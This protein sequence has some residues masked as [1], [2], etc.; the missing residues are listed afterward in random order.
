MHIV[1]GDLNFNFLKKSVKLI[2]IINQIERNTMTVFEPQT[3]TRE[4]ITT[5]TCIDVFFTNFK[6][7]AFI[8]INKISDHYTEGP[9]S[10]KKKKNFEN[11]RILKRN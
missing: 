9:D 5:K 2:L 8:E 1:C 11:I 6:T 4:K 7:K 10:A 3:L